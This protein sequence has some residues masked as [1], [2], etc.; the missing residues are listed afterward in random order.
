MLKIFRKTV[1][2]TTLMISVSLTCAA[3]GPSVDALKQAP[4]GA[5][6]TA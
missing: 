2:G 6:I 5:V 4:N 3:S 1:V